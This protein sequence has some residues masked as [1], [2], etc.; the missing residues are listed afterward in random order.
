MKKNISRLGCGVD[1]SKD[2]FHSCFGYSNLSGQFKVT[3]SKKFDN[4]P[5]GIT[6]FIIWLNEAI[7]K[8]DPKREFPFQLLMET[9]GVYHESLCVASYNAGFNVCL[10]VAS[11]VKL[12]LKS[13]GHDSKN[14]TLDAKG[15]CQMSCERSIRSWSPCSPNIL[16]LRSALRHRKSLKEDKVR[17]ENQIH[18]KQ[19]SCFKNKDVDASLTRM[20]KAMVKEIDKMEQQILKLYDQDEV[21]KERLD[22]IV[23][24][25]YGV[26]IFTAL[27]VVAETNGFSEI[28]S[29]KQ[30]ASYAGY[31]IIENQSGKH[32][33]KTR[34]SKK[35]NARIRA[36]LYMAALS[37]TN[38]KQGALYA[39][40]QRIM[41]KNPKIY[42]LG[43]VALQRKLLI[44]IYTLYK[45]NEAFDPNYE[46]EKARKKYE[47]KNS[48]ELCPE[49]HEIVEA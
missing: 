20:H 1:I 44:L 9:T 48:P 3:R 15:I 25:L 12:Y 16:M 29:A 32:S 42:K 11:R 7:K 18:A 36:Q 19:H 31:D 34:I 49:L 39:F 21:L 5:S 35:G 28:R 22:K 10:E 27:L 17:V 41:V 40:F 38:G 45:K 46:W 43:N 8:Q 4:S 24:S 23:G 37:V 14:D 6:S 47:E 2:K 13:I 30:L 33:G 26:G